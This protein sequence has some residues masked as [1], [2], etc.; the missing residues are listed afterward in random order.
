M[1]DIINEAYGILQCRECPW[2]KMCVSP[3][4]FTSE[5]I[6]RQMANQA[7]LANQPDNPEA[8]DLIANMAIAAQNQLLE[9]CPIFIEKL[10]SSAGLAKRIK[11]VVQQWRDEEKHEA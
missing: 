3:M 1:S 8:Q 5:D 4:R 7:P 9:G 2:Y 10:R 11:E 6:R